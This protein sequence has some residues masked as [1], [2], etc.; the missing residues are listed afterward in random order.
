MADVRHSRVESPPWHALPAAAVLERLASSPAGLTSA[1]ARRR[2]GDV[3]PNVLPPP[4]T[5]SA[6]RILAD[7][8]RGLVVLLLVVAAAV[9]LAAGETIDA[10]AIAGVLVLTVAIGFF[11]EL[12]ARRA[13]DALLR[14]D[15]ARAAVLRDGRVAPMEARGAVPGDVVELDAGQA[16]PADCRLLQA[17]ELTVNEAALTG[18]SLP[19]SKRVEPPVDV[20]APLPDRA[21]MVYKAT[22]VATGRARAVVTGTGAATEVGRIGALV[23]DV[24]EPATPIERRLG[25]LGAQLI[26]IALAVAA[27]VGGIELARGAPFG[28]VVATAIALAV[29]AVPEGLPIIA[30]VAM[31]IGVRR[32]A[33]RHAVV[34]R[35]PAVESLGSA[36]VICTDKTGTLTTG[37]MTVTT[38]WVAG[39]EHDIASSPRGPAPP[40]DALVQDA[41]RVAALANRAELHDAA[42]PSRGGHGDPTEVALLVA[43]HGAGLDRGRLRVE[44]PEVGELPFSSERQLMATFHREREGRLRA[45]VKG[46]PGRLLALCDRVA[47]LEGE[48]PLDA[49]TAAALRAVNESLAARGLRV[50]ALASGD[51]ADP[52]ETATRSLTFLGYVGMMDP[53]APGVR[54]TVQRLQDAGIRIVMLTGDQRLT[55]GAIAAQL[56]LLREG[57]EVLDGR[58]LPH[59]GDDELTIRLRRVRA[60]SRVGPADK[61]RVVTALQADGE[62]VAMLGDGVNDA[63]ALRKADVGVAMGGRGTDVAKEA[64]AVVLQDDRFETIG[65]AVEE[66][67]IIF[68]NVRKFIF[69]LFS[70]NLAEIVVLLGA[71]LVGLPALLPIQILWLNLVTDTF[72]ALALATEPGEPG[73]MRRAPERPDAP[74]LS[75]GLLRRVLA[76][77]LLVAAP[78]LLVLWWGGSGAARA[79]TLGFTTLGLAQLLH[80]GNARSTGHVLST[81]AAAANRIALLA[82]AAGVA[83]QI[84]AVQVPVLSR[85]LGT[86]RLDGRDWAIA[87]TLGAVP[88]VVGQLAKLV[89]HRALRRESAASLPADRRAARR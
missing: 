66:G 42:D 3:G 28:V 41:L 80:L 37:E 73:V 83:L 26:W 32:M 40:L 12:R 63:P 9:A 88:A 68:D 47:T 39:R 48:R 13:M 20:D 46:A 33:R 34:R 6:L 70:C 82:L 56:G 17:T 87:G 22:I 4:R 61:L 74:L 76:Y 54:E 65:A 24:D 51:V 85:L 78:V 15:V 89:R 69:Y 8:A 14:L 77:G 10:L 49:V 31:G 86:V 67:R 71:G 75:R 59:V 35:L 30:T 81:R 57:D 7:N 1:E 52:T 16:V 2:L 25:A 44:W 72:P 5:R 79:T 43:A 23:S 53:P 11:T 36:T 62:I 21:V 38:L 27:L 55:A 18:E 84:A 60:I 50:L 29:A 45:L 19:V 64:A 58:E